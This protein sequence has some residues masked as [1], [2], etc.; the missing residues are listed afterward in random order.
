MTQP[1][2]SDSLVMGLHIKDWFG[3]AQ[4]NHRDYGPTLDLTMSN[5]L[6][7]QSF[8]QLDFDLAN[9]LV[10]LVDKKVRELRGRVHS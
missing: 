2:E 1:D 10:G 9:Q 8:I 7:Q 6:G 5:H 3:I 4:S